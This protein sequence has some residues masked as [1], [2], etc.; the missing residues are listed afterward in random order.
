MSVDTIRQV[1]EAVGALR[2]HITR[3]NGERVLFDEEGHPILSE[4]EAFSDHIMRQVDYNLAISDALWAI[5]GVE[6]ALEA[7]NER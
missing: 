3:E 4:E 2:K 5:Y 7:R 1:V 6:A